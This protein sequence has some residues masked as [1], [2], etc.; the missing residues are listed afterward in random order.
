MKKI[1]KWL[2]VPLLGLQLITIQMAHAGTLEPTLIPHVYEDVE[3]Q[4]YQNLQGDY[5]LSGSLLDLG[6]NKPLK[7]NYSSTEVANNLSA[8]LQVFPTLVEATPIRGIYAAVFKDLVK[9]S[10]GSGRFIFRDAKLFDSEGN[11]YSA[12]VLVK[13][14]EIQGRKNLQVLNLVS[15]AEMIVYK[16]PNERHQITVFTDTDCPFCHKLHKD[17]PAYLKQGIS[18]RYLFYPRAGVGSQAYKQAISVW[19]NADRKAALNAAEQGYQVDAASCSHPVD[20][21]LEV[22]RRL[23]LMGTPVIVVGN[24]KLLHGYHSIQ[25]VMPYL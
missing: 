10:D 23:N 6:G 11:D 21:H 24:G 7:Q 1:I 17:V 4:S 18:V 9:Y 2:L 25:E 16:A 13:A 22:V 20:K 3:R 14:A 12:V 5:R 19:C 15:E 8:R